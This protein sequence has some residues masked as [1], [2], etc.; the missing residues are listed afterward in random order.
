M[1]LILGSKIGNDPHIKRFLKGTFRSRP[2]KPRY[3]F[4]WDPGVMLRYWNAQGPNHQLSLQ[5]LSI[6]TISLLA[7]VTAHRVQTFAGIKTENIKRTETELKI[8]VTNLIKTSSPQSH[9]PLL[10]LP[11]FEK[12]HICVARTILAYLE[13]TKSLRLSNCLFMALKQ[14]HKPVGSQTLSRWIKMGLH[15]SGVN[16]DIFTAHSTRHASTSAGFNQGL[17]LETIRKAAGWSES[18]QVFARFYNRQVVAEEQFA[19]TILS[20]S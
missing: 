18:S 20:L 11:F 19:R 2:P 14:P 10:N 12:E 7:L 1:S 17:S 4:T 9:Q 8:F 13:R 5:Q 3:L 15:L 16:T 6:K